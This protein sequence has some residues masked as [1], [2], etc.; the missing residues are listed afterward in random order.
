MPALAS[1]WPCFR[2]RVFLLPGARPDHPITRQSVHIGGEDGGEADLEKPAAVQ[3]M[4]RLASFSLLIRFDKRGT[5]GSR[6][7]A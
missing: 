1:L 2:V 7:Q 6:C 4:N 5:G 3:V